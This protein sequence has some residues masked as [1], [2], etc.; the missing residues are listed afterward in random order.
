M[1]LLLFSSLVVLSNGVPQMA[2]HPQMNLTRGLQPQPMELQ[3]FVANLKGK[4]DAKTLI[5]KLVD[6]DPANVFDDKSLIKELVEADPAK[7]KEVVALVEAMVQAAQA[8]LDRLT[9]ESTNANSAYDAAVSKYDAAV[10]T[11]VKAQAAEEARIVAAV[12]AEK[13]RVDARVVA[14]GLEAQAITDAQSAKDVAEGAKTGA[15]DNLDA[16]KTVKEAEIASLKQVISVLEGLI[17]NGSTYQSYPTSQCL[18]SST[19]FAGDNSDN[20]IFG[21]GGS[22]GSMTAHDCQ[23]M[24]DDVNNVDSHGRRC[25]AFEHSS[26]DPDVVASCA[27]AWGCDST[28]HWGGGTSYIRQ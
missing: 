26:Q 7:V 28:S 6:T 11:Q 4:F 12:A 13:I 16:E 19:P 15:Q 21:G 10:V 18:T 14:A 8:D 23:V 2:L 3:K 1:L 22:D 9:L 17:P 20:P 27:L 5:E 25:V 24:C